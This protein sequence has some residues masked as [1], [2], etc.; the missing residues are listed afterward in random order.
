MRKNFISVLEGYEIQKMSKLGDIPTCN[1][2]YKPIFLCGTYL[3]FKVCMF[4][5][6]S[7]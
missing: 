7:V 6:K 5:L 2:N 4:C 3:F 1:Y